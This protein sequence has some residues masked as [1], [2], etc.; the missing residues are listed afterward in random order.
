MGKNREIENQ[1]NPS[2]RAD[3]WLWAV[4]LF[5]NRALAVEACRNHQVRIN[6]QQ[7]KPSRQVRPG[8]RLEV[9]KGFLT[10][11]VRA[12]KVLSRRVGAKRVD[13]YL[14]D[15]TAPEA[16]EKAN[17]AR[18]Q[19]KESVPLRDERAGRPTKK[20]RRDLDELMEAADEK[21][22]FLR[23]VMKSAKRTSI[24]LAAGLLSFSTFPEC[25]A[26]DP[27]AR[28]FK[29]SDKSLSFQISKNLSV[30][31]EEILPAMDEK[32]GLM[33]GLSA[34][35]SVLI[36]A[37]PEGAPSEIL[38]S[39]GK[40]TYNAARDEVVLTGWPAV[41][42]GIQILRATSSETY[43]RV[44]R[45]TGKWEIQGPHRIDISFDA[46][47]KKSVKDLFKRGLGGKR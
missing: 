37:K 25:L 8:D 14:E 12:K 1:G 40:A 28:S 35:G 21:E 41:K 24:I 34:T 36:K 44:N 32:T 26:A 22:K 43:V 45:A 20:E 19:A 23:K 4:R 33:T 5:K 47:G 3:V 30:T 9:E 39:C 11:T 38:I 16:F 27:P 18:R 2:V 6:G 10:R 46:G 15:L 31:A 7:V 42:S 13:E 29:P 17:E